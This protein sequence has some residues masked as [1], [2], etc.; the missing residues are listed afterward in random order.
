[1][2]ASLINGNG[3][4]QL[5]A[6]VL[7]VKSIIWAFSLG[8]GTSGGIFA[9]LLMIG[10]ALGALF[11]PV[12]PS[13]QAG[14]WPLAGMAAVLSGAIGCPLT[15]AVLTLELTHNY[16]LLL[17]VLAS[18]VAAHAFTVLFQKRSILTERI[19]RRGHHLSREYGVDP[20]EVILV[21]E[22]MRTFAVVLP[23]DTTAADARLWLVG[24]REAGDRRGQRL[25]PLVDSLGRLAGV[26]TR[27]ELAIFA[28]AAGEPQTTIPS[29]APVFAHPE[30]TLRSIAERMA[31]SGLFAMPVVEHGTRKLL[32]LVSAEELL[33]GRERAHARENKHERLRMPFRRM[34]AKDILAETA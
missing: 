14:A 20:L 10:G 25:Y 31:T 16:G 23:A 30:E 6:G 18:S 32:G 1:V 27:R 29:V 22:V 3:A 4:W 19:S 34:R 2:I 24:G 15:G 28:K 8:S 13:L 12:L 11:A 9:P 17:P 26:I 21:S 7:I 33:K 5:I